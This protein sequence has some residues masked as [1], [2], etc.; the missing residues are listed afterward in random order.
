[1]QDT[2]SVFEHLRSILAP[3]GERM[4]VTTN[5]DSHY[6]VNTRHVQ[7]NKTPLF[8]G[9]VQVK[10]GGVSYHLMPVYVRP[11]LLASVSPELRSKMQGKSC[12]SF[13]EPDTKLFKELAALTKAG[14]ASFEEQGLA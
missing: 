3:Y 12:F 8:F 11:E 14:F 13:K 5:T 10:K 9:A 4:D 1:M 2:S 6:Y 7:K